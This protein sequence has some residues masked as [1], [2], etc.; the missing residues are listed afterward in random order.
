MSH[1]DSILATGIFSKFSVSYLKG[2]S[3]MVTAPAILAVLKREGLEVREAE[4]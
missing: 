3:R 2:Q 4:H 1:K